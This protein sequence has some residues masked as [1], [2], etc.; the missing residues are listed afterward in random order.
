M[1][2]IVRA[3]VFV[4][5]MDSA[6]LAHAQLW[7]SNSSGVSTTGKVEITSSASD[8]LELSSGGRISAT[9][10]TNGSLLHSF[11]NTSTGT[12]ASVQIGFTNN[13]GSG[14]LGLFGGNHSSFPSTL[15]LVNSISGGDLR[16]GSGGGSDG[17]Q[18]VSG[19]EGHVFTGGTISATGATTGTRT[20]SLTNTDSG[21]TSLLEFRLVNDAGNY[22]TL[23]YLSSNFTSFNNAL[24]LVNTASNAPIRIAGTGASSTITMLIN[25]ASILALSAT[26]ATSTVPHIGPV[27]SSSAPTYSFTGDTNTGFYQAAADRI[28]VATGGVSKI[29][30]GT[31][32]SIASQIGM[33]SIAAGT[34]AIPGPTIIVG[35]NNSGSGAAGTLRLFPRTGSASALWVNSSLLRIGTAPTED[36][37]ASHTGGTVVGDQSSSLDTKENLEPFTDYAGALRSVVTAPL[38]RFT[39]RDGR[40]NGESFMGYVTDYTDWAGKD[41]DEQ[42]P[43][44]RALD[45][46]TILGMLTAAMKELDRRVGVLEGRQ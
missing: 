2:Y 46:G 6:P 41:A 20:H 44:G 15:F 45:E 17:I 29:E 43:N 19:T 32:G 27:G 35:Q 36:D 24:N 28:G 18:Y 14:G 37:S 39:Y 16:L 34:G 23:Q 42:H 33:T 5:V 26:E 12:S 11:G 30:I 8:A 7:V 3:C 13:S 31:S 21:S 10:S 25:S 9:G 40:Y 38:F 1:A 4:A 22:G